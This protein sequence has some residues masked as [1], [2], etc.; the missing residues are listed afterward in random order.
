MSGGGNY[1]G[2]GG[3]GGQEDLKCEDL[4]FHTSLNS[5]DPDIVTKLALKEVLKLEQRKEGGPLLAITRSKKV[6]GSIAG[7]LLLRLLR[8]IEEG[9]EYEAVVVKITGGNVE[10]E[11]HHKGE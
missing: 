10:V 7:S 1:G 9:H 11:V 6:A 2:D 4:R 5:P 3:G 8:C